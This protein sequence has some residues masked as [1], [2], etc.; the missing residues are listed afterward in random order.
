MKTKVYV[1]LPIAGHDLEETKKYVN[2]VK[3]W[4]EEKGYEVMTPFDACSEPD[5]PYSYYMGESIKALL[6]CDAVYFVFDWAT[7]KGCMAEFEIARVYGK[8]I[9]M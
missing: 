3:K 7:S 6:E 4:L 2:Q 8:Q 1:S 5:K 9:M